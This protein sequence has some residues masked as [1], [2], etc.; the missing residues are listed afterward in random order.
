M[1]TTG[2]ARG[3]E[4]IRKEEGPDAY[5]RQIIQVVLDRFASS[6]TANNRMMLATASRYDMYRGFYQ[7]RY[8]SFRNNVHIP[9]IFSM[10]QSDV[11]YKSQTSF[12]T[13]PIVE[14]EGYG[15]EDAAV[16]RKNTVLVSAQMKDDDSFRKAVDFFT[17]ADLYG[18]AILQHGW[19]FSQEE[20]LFREEIRNVYTGARRF[21]RN[22]QVVTTFDGPHW[23]N[24][25]ILDWFPEP[26][27]KT[28]RE[29]R[30]AIRRLWMDI[31]DLRAL[32]HQGVYSLEA[33]E[34]ILQGRS[35][36]AMNTAGFTYETRMRLYRNAMDELGRS[37]DKT[38]RPVEV[39]EM[40]GTLPDEILPDDGIKS[41]VISI[42]NGHAL[43]RN[44]PNPYW[45]GQIPFLAYSPIPDPH[46]FYGIGKVEIAEKLQAAANRFTN[47]K[48]D[49]LDLFVDPVFMYDRNKGI[50]PRKLYM[51]AGRP[52]PVDGPVDG[53][54][55]APIVPDLRGLQHAEVE[56]EQL[57]R[58][59][60]QGVGQIEDTTMGTA[61]VSKRQT[62][63]EFLGRQE[64]ISTRL[65]L[66][67]RLA[68]EGWIE[69]LANAFRYLNRQHLQVPREIRILGE[70]ATINP[71]TGEQLAPEDRRL[72]LN[73]L[74]PDYDVRAKGA[75][76]AMS[77]AQQQQNLAMLI[78]MIGANPAAATYVNWVAVLRQT[79]KAFEFSNM[80]E[81]L[82]VS[83][84]MMAM[85]AQMLGGGP[86]GAPN[87]QP[88]EGGPPAEM[89][90]GAEAIAMLQPGFT[91]G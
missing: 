47:Q 62:R 86:R 19:K 71:I 66:E 18:T 63:A 85:N 14:M 5:D 20:R 27:V 10:I 65:L 9:L 78:Q 80:N 54:V 48:L 68:E 4:T 69:P 75:T 49:A 12:G 64:S 24:V 59:M 23:E 41:R 30:W 77:K 31:D 76:Q 36:V 6:S 56:V 70:Q 7:S 32:A 29:M 11:A 42:G 73:D 25:D 83:P 89:A 91:Y 45:H 22:R 82:S 3:Y 28:I 34:D 60:Q 67:T 51:R 26:G 88:Q 16:A 8:H 87:E 38:D 81:M 43:L 1:A 46:Y 58:W 55:L 79:F 17:S 53:S 50:D 74:Y 39:L 57:W 44:E 40:W 2:G 72:D 84:Q 37:G 35:S 21:Q 61:G 90:P 52:I 33:V 13:W 15:P